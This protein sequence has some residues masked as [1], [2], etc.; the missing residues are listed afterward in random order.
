MPRRALFCKTCS[1]LLNELVRVRYLDVG[2]RAAKHLELGHAKPDDFDP[3]LMCSL[4]DPS[5][6]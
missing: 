5:L 2:E 6:K 4:D 1:E 3:R